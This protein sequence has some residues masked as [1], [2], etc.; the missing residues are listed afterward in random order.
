MLVYVIFAITFLITIGGFFC[1]LDWRWQKRMKDLE[2][3]F[4]R[5]DLPQIDLDEVHTRVPFQ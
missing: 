3:I 2:I 1:I 5:L 4:K